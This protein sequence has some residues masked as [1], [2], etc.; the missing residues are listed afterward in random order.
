MPMPARFLA[1]PSVPATPGAACGNRSATHVTR[2][3][4]LMLLLVAGTGLAAPAPTMEVETWP[5]PTAADAAQPD[6]VAAADGSLLL[7]WLEKTPGEQHFRMSRQPVAAAWSAP[8]QIAG[9]ADLIANWADFPHLIALPDGALWAHWLQ[10]SGASNYDYSVALVR[11]I[12]AGAHWSPPQ[13]VNLPNS[14]GDHGFVSLWPQTADTLGI[15]WLDSRQKAA[16]AAHGGGHAPAAGATHGP[17]APSDAAMMLRAATFDAD[18]QRRAEWPL[19]VS[20]CD[21][22]QTGA[23]M[24]ASGAVVV[25][26]GRTPDEI[27]DIYLTRFTGAGWTTPVRVHAD[28]WKIAGCPV[29]GPAVAALGDRVWVAWYTEAGG[30]PSVRVALSTDAG[31]T[32][33]APR[34]V[35]AGPDV[36]GRLALAA[37]A[38]SVWL[39]WFSEAPAPTA[40]T[41]GAGNQQLWLARY[42]LDLAAAPARVVVAGL[43]ARGRASGMPRMALQRGVPHLVWTDV[44]ERRPRLHGARVRIA[45]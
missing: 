16:A 37:D 32:F 1:M 36:L 41:V 29:N 5:L 12:D 24:T 42:P 31:A 33:G 40:S 44:V 27:R 25:Y 4:L 14:P 22:C 38:A 17:H 39:S 30:Q 34:I 28:D 8:R 23:A 18:G 9:G 43:A 15:A 10:R 11:S 21:C 2:T 20:T 3:A 13:I 7:S 26:R 45:P 6:L 19:D 35:A